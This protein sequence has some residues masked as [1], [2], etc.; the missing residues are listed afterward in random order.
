MLIK[1]LRDD[2]HQPYATVVSVN[3]NQIGI[4][5]CSPKDSFNRKRGRNIAFNRALIK[6]PPEFEEDLPNR[7]ILKNGEYKSIGEVILSEIENMKIR[8]QKYYWKD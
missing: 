7:H 4:A 5:I 8:S 6:N 2:F 3:E 1:H